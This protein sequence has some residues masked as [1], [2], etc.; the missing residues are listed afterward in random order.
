MLKVDSSHVKCLTRLKTVV[1]RFQDIGQAIETF[2]PE[3]NVGADAWRRTG[4]LTFDGN[5]RI[6]QK[7]TYGK[8]RTPTVSQQEVL[9]TDTDYVNRYPSI[10][11]TTS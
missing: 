11:Q 3:S 6:K 1:D 5:L 4:V 2:V 9:T 8:Q 10:L 7:V